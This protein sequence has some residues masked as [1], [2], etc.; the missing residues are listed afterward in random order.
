MSGIVEMG[1]EILRVNKPNIVLYMASILVYI[2]KLTDNFEKK[3]LIRVL[4]VA[5]KL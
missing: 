2:I 4:K 5:F 3:G 1:K